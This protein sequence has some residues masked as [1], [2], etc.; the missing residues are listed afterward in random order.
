MAVKTAIATKTLR[1]GKMLESHEYKNPKPE[2]IRELA[3]YIAG[4]HLAPY[5]SKNSA[6]AL[7]SN[8]SSPTEVA[9]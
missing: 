7:Y 5:F 1:I 3:M 8:Q 4:N 6:T 2:H 9:V